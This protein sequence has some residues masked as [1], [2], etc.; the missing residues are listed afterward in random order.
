MTDDELARLTQD[1][2]DGADDDDV[3]PE[4]LD[5]VVD[6]LQMHVRLGVLLRDTPDFAAGVV[7]EIRFQSDSPQFAQGVVSRLK[8]DRFRLLGRFAAVAAAVLV[9]GLTGWLF[10]APPTA[11]AAG[12]RRALLVVGRLPLEAGDQ[13]VRD[14]LEKLGF[15]VTPVDSAR[16]RARDAAGYS[17]VAVSSTA[18]AEE[19]VD[20]P[21]EM[22]LR[23]RELGVPLLTWEPR[24][25]HELG[26]TSKGVHGTD[27]AAT[28][29]RSRLAILE[30]AHP[31]AAG[32]SGTVEVVRAPDR[33]SWGR[34]SGAAA[35][36]A[37]LDGEPEHTALF[38]YE[39]GAPMDGGSRA[40]ARR[41]GCF[42]FDTTATRLSEAGGRLFD[43]AV[44]WCAGIQ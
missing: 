34:L 10:L 12:A 15:A 29:N 14:R 30:P 42:L 43:A 36:V 3:A 7:R 27:W 28:K 22:R 5:Q 1:A 25:F 18:L 41:V 23:F 11:P 9:I 32:L 44:R 6:Q 2:I 37:S 24:L 26:M 21:D 19:L 35:R 38:G 17:L 31:L 8:G 16:A 13:A 33:L 4:A 20:V 40:P 39:A